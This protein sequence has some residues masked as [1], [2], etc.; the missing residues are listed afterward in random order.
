MAAGGFGRENFGDPLGGGGPISV[1]R[2]QAVAG[3]VVRVVFTEA[4]TFRSAAGLSDAQNATNYAFSVDEGDATAPAAVAVDG[5]LI[6]GPAVAVGNGGA[7]DER[8]ADVHVDRALVLGITY[9]VTV[10]RVT[11]AIGGDL[12]A[13][14][15]AAFGG[16]APLVV[17]QPGERTRDSLDVA[18]GVLGSWTAGPGGDLL[19]QGGLDGYRKRI[20]RRATTPL[21]SFSFLRRG[22]GTQVRLKEVA[23]LAQLAALK[24]DLEAQIKREPETASVQVTPQLVAGAVLILTIDAKTKKGAVVSA[25]IQRAADGSVAF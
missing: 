2:A 7:A 22:Y 21:D 8:A 16:V 14:T 9:R 11:A 20:L 15:S 6:E 1:A 3:R 18:N 25:T 24:V 5:S 13:P 19:N 17:R 23:S 4:P 10:S 12:G